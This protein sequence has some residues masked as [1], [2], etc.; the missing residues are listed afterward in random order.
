MRISLSVFLAAYFSQTISERKNKTW[1]YREVGNMCSGGLPMYFW[2]VPRHIFLI[3]AVLYI[4]FSLRFPYKTLYF[5][6]ISGIFFFFVIFPY[7]LL[8]FSVSNFSGCPVL[9]VWIRAPHFF[10]LWASDLFLF[11]SYHWISRQK[12]QIDNDTAM[13][14]TKQEN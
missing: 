9:V 1:G 14:K 8:V 10:G 6:Y 4:N 2:R 11:V 12:L 5:Q 7:Y 3:F 13:S